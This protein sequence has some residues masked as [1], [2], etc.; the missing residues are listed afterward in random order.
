MFRK[1]VRKTK[2]GIIE[3]ITQVIVDEEIPPH[4]VY[5]IRTMRYSRYG[6]SHDVRRKMSLRKNEEKRSR[7]GGS[8]R[9]GKPKRRNRNSKRRSKRKSKRKSRRR[10]R[11]GIYKKNSPYLSCYVWK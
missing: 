8:F 5:Q 3:D 1:Q 10:S 7:V 6:P 9:D 2:N 11:D 4:Q